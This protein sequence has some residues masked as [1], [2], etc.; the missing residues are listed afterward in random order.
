MF[1]TFW[2]LQI[3][4]TKFGFNAGAQV[5]PFLLISTIFAFLILLVLIFPKVKSEF[6]NLY[7][8]Q[9]SQFWKLY[10]ANG[11]QAGF[12]TCL[13]LIGISL[14][15]A[16]NAGF[17]VKLTTVTTILF[18]W[19]LLKERMSWIKVAVVLLMLTGAYL[20]TTQA[21]VLIPQP[22]DLFLLAACVCWSLGTVLVRFFLRDRPIDPD[23]VTM[24]KPMAS[25]PVILVLISV[26][27]IVPFSFGE[28]T[29]V[30]DCCQLGSSGI[31]YSLLNGTCLAMAWIYLYRTLKVS[32]ASYLTMMSMITPVMV[33]ILAV[34]FLGETLVWIQLIGAA[35]IILS[36]ILVY[37]SDIAYA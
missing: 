17:L 28:L 35:L 19:I 12:G 9:K 1:S 3:I 26:I 10:A 13:A 29:Q 21:Q 4:F 22:G 20:L 31:L 8:K 14:T 33:S 34:I 24:Q 30:F 2:A 15:N 11:I 27:A 5:F 32:T 25:L 6:I 36:G 23:V 16:I 37:F 18:A 7:A